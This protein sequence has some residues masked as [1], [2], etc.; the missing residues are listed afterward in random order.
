VVASPPPPPP[1]P[2][3]N[4]AYRIHDLQ[5]ELALHS[6]LHP[7]PEHEHRLATGGT[8]AGLDPQPLPGQPYTVMG[9]D[10]A[11]EESTTYDPCSGPVESYL[12]LSLV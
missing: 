8:V 5:L 9:G 11:D 12:S 2:L 6:F 10:R 4:Y 7:A 1:P 3:L